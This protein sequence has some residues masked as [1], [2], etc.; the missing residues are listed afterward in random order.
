ML[1]NVSQSILREESVVL[2]RVFLMA[3]A[4]AAQG[5]RVLC[6]VSKD[7]NVA[8]LLTYQQAQRVRVV[9]FYRQPLDPARLPMREL[10]PEVV[11]VEDAPAFRPFT[12]R[13]PE[14]TRTC[15]E[16]RFSC[17]SVAVR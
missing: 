2:P 11:L 7:A 1:L 14:Q 5:H 8:H 13:L 10:R 17:Y 6:I 15:H 3:A 12:S 4:I 9:E 16:E